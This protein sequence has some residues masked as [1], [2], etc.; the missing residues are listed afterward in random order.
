MHFVVSSKEKAEEKYSNV[1]IWN[2]NTIATL[3]FNY[4]FWLGGKETNWGTETWQ[5]IF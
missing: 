5:L 2:D 4:S 1:N 3:Y